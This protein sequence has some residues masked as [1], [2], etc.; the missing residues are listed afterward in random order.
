MDFSKV[1]IN[2]KINKINTVKKIKKKRKIIKRNYCVY[3]DINYIGHQQ[4]QNTNKHK[5]KYQNFQ[6]L[7]K[8]KKIKELIKTEDDDINI[9]NFRM[10]IIQLEKR[11]NNR[12]WC[13]DC[14]YFTNFASSFTRHKKS[15]R[16]FI[17][18]NDLLGKNEDSLCIL[19]KNIETDIETNIENENA[20]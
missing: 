14:C 3:C 1:E 9:Y 18:T 13:E 10:V 5:K 20:N 8:I 2:T 17:K 11:I 12:H 19:V 7:K 4:H 16:H 6:I 15:N